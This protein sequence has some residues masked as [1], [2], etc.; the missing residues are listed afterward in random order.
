MPSAKIH[1]TTESQCLGRISLHTIF[2][3]DGLWQVLASMEAAAA[4]NDASAQQGS[5]GEQ[6]RENEKEIPDSDASEELNSQ[7][8]SAETGQLLTARTPSGSPAVIVITSF[9]S[10]LEGLYIQRPR[11]LVHDLVLMLN[12]RIR[13]LSRSSAHLPLVVLLNDTKNIN[14]QPEQQRSNTT[15]LN[16]DASKFV[17]DITS[18]IQLTAVPAKLK[19]LTTKFGSIFTNLLDLHILCQ[20]DIAIRQPA[21]MAVGLL[22]CNPICDTPWP[23]KMTI[24]ACID[25][26]TQGLWSGALGPTVQREGR[27]VLLEI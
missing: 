13:R 22:Q 6:E 24:R 4:Q 19:T 20:S 5:Q 14:E 21:T 16:Q 18:N 11:P 7:C 23:S 17:T 25:L 3:I 1:A 2:D 8:S 9:T 26:D 15:V 10:L 27:T 12:M